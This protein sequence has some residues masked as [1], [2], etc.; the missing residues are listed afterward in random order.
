LRPLPIS[1][2]ST[3][4]LAPGSLIGRKADVD[5]A[6]ALLLERKAR[7]L[8]VVGPPGV[9][10]TRL[11]LAVAAACQDDFD[12]GAVFV[13]LS[14]VRSADLVLDT[15]ASAFGLRQQANLRPA[16]QLQAYLG[17]SDV[18]LVLDN[19]EHLLEAGLDLARLL[20][21]SADLV[22]LATSRTALNLRWEQVYSVAPL[23]L[24][25]AVELFV[26]RARATRPDFGD[27]PVD[28]TA[29]AQICA[30]LDGLPLAI[31]LAAARSL[32]LSPQDLLNRLDGRLELLAGGPRDATSRH[33]TLREAIDWSYD[34]LTDLERGV[35]RRLGVFVGSFT[36]EG[37]QAVALPDGG[38][39]LD[40]LSSLAQKSLVRVEPASVGAEPRFRLLETVREYA[41]R[42]LVLEGEQADSQLLH[43]EFF[44]VLVEAGYPRNFGPDQPAFA[45]RLDRDHSN[46]RQALSWAL[47]TPH[48]EIALRLGAALHWYWYGR[49]YLAEGLGYLERALAQS[50]QASAAARAGAHRAAGALLLNQGSYPR[51]L[52][53]LEK[54]VAAGRARRTD[55]ASRSELAMALGVLGVAQVAAGRY[56][57][58]DGSIRE[59]LAI[60]E[61]QADEWG[62]ATAREVLGAIAALRGDAELA[63]TL[64]SS[65]LEV[66]RRLGSRE[67]IARALDVLG[68]SAAL[69]GRLVTAA[70]CFEESLS[71]RREATNKP[72]TAAV[73]GRLA[74]VAYLGE[75][76]DRA[77]GLYRESLALAQEVGDA[78]GVV[79]C[80]GQI[81]ALGL[82]CGADRATIARLGSAVRHHQ[83]A[84]GLPS[85]P[86][87]QIAAKR[88]AAALRAELS[89][90]GL[91]T[92]WLG[93]RVLDLQ[94]ATRLGFSLLDRLTALVESPA[95]SPQSRRLTRRE[96]QVAILVAQGLTN[97]QIAE[98]LVIAQRTV[99]THV[100]RI[101]AK[102]NFDTRAQIAAWA[103]R[104]G[105]LDPPTS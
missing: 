63:E 39:A 88:L 12:H 7:L 61:S 103:A 50:D 27:G 89:P 81:A 57:A 56:D 37:A 31:E 35:F 99:D 82:A 102:L 20:S 34:L 53:H 97:R 42:R 40:L 22:I 58:A 95:T 74:L 32:V 21:T 105:L 70:E 98:E 45:A 104:Q 15:I 65:S 30:R 85:P 71:L 78:A 72:A 48:V 87:E 5:T 77:A 19:L 93:G 28:D 60:F 43:A 1:R 54:A 23:S 6:R 69:R 66:H 4:P 33:Q 29:I 67:N 49:G 10:K 9:G 24:E 26:D 17:D 68:Y 3:L 100:E 16:D 41:W 55:R 86:V 47:E 84:L 51:A 76:W 96:T 92:A 62:V 8:T 73:L 79:R 13:D 52:V 38:S 75:Q 14:P 91:A 90:V 80:L 64:A 36:V 11:A 46:L 2:R 59:S 83:S 101:L 94:G 18:L 44:M 25:A